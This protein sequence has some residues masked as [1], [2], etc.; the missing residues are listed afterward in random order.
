MPGS[1]KNKKRHQSKVLSKDLSKK[2]GIEKCQCPEKAQMY[3]ALWGKSTSKP[4]LVRVIEVEEDSTPLH[5][6]PP[7]FKILVVDSISS[8]PCYCV[9]STKKSSVGIMN[10]FLDWIKKYQ[11]K[12]KNC[13]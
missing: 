11:N 8:F 2:L 12:Y 6:T 13:Y 4:Y 9:N 10:G 1:V 7:A 3:I 5:S